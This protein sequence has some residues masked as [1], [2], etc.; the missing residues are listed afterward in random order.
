MSAPSSDEFTQPNL[1]PIL[2]MVFQLIT[3]FMLVIN[4]KAAETDTSL[5]LPVIGSAKPA[6]TKNQGELLILNI[7]A[8]GKL[9]VRGREEPSIEG[10][11]LNEIEI[12]KRT[13]RGAES[14]DKQVTVVIRAD[15]KTTVRIDHVLA[16]KGWNCVRCWVGPNVGS[17]HRPVLADLVWTGTSGEAPIAWAR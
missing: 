16:G 8:D 11:I 3:F 5:A 1:T 7:N 15:R 4:F 17:P 9:M 10:F 2:D 6:E 13:H 12:L 14:D